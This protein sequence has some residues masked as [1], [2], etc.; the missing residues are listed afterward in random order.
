MVVYK[1]IQLQSFVNA[2]VSIKF[3]ANGMRYLKIIVIIMTGIKALMKL[4][5]GYAV[6]FICTYITAVIPMDHFTHQPEICFFLIGITA[7]LLHK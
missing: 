7:H 3:P 4:I 6:Q 2:S 1:G 5:I